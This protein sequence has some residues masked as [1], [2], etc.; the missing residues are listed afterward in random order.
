MQVLTV[1]FSELVPVPRQKFRGARIP[2]HHD[3]SFRSHLTGRSA[4]QAMRPRGL[5]PKADSRFVRH[6]DGQHRSDLRR[7]ATCKGSGFDELGHLTPMRRLVYASCSSGQRIAIR[8]P[9]DP[10]SPAEPLPSA[11]SSPCRASRGR[12]PQGR[13]ALPGAPK[14]TASPANGRG[15]TT[16][17]L[18]PTAPSRARVP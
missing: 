9:S 15:P 11:N 1:V 18:K 5:L 7:T 14:K 10:R 6:V 3:R 16:H 12:R 2:E 8:L 17:E 13:C 4:R